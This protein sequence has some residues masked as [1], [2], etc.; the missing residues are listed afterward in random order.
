VSC[1]YVAMSEGYGVMS[2]RLAAMS[3]GPGVMS[4]RLA[5]SEGSGVMSL[6]L[7]VYVVYL[8]AMKMSLQL[9]RKSRVI[10]IKRSGTPIN[11]PRQAP[12]RLKSSVGT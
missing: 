5:K 12:S 8:V 3:K 10:V 6:R 4:L 1:L 11:K 9:S 7:V 2:L